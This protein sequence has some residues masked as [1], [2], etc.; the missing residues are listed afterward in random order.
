MLLR[1]LISPSLDEAKM[2]WAKSGKKVVRKFRCSGGQRHGR[3]VSNIAQCFAKPDINKRNKLRMTKAR[4][5]PKMARKARKTKR[6][7]PASRRVQ[8]LNKGTRIKR[9]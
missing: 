7:N 3:I 2:A 6:V 1:D 5:G 4:L 9:L 8:A